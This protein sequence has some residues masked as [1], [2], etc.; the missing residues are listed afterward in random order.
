MLK[1]SNSHKIIPIM[2]GTRKKLIRPIVVVA[3]M[4]F[5]LPASSQDLSS[6][7]GGVFNHLGVGLSVGTGGIGFD[8]ATP[9]TD[10]VALRAGVS[11]WPKAKYSQD[12]HLNNKDGDFIKSDVNMEAK[13]NIFDAKLLADI[14]PINTSSFHITLGAFFGKSKIA[15]AY[16]TE[17]FLKP[18]NWG[19]KGIKLGTDYRIS[20]DDEGNAHA[21]VNVNGVKPYIGIGFGRAVPRKHRVAVS[22]DLGVK[23]WGTPKLGAN[24]KNSWGEES[25][26]KFTYD[27]LTD[28]DD[29]DLK[30]AMEIASKIKVFPV[31]NIRICGKIF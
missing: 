8:V 4:F 17:Q 29:Q 7:D 30:D 12:I 16:N 22:C 31:L 5:A 26:H 6:S 9:V 27:E 11:F 2:K 24:T 25:Y 13:L 10:F 1:L 19:N 28:D 3:M 18:E 21:D 23:L 15:E 20:S 14:Y